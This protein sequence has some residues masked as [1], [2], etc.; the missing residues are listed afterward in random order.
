MGFRSGAYAKVWDVS[1]V[2]DAVTTLR[3]SIS[4]KDKK[5]GDYVDDFSG[6]IRVIG[7]AAAKNASLIKPGDRIRLGDVDVS[8]R[9]DRDKKVEYTTYKVFGFDNVSDNQ[10]NSNV[11][12]D[13]AGESILD[14]VDVDDQSLPF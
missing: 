4:R 10:S 6:F 12:G 11:A 5:T 9:Y 8:T 13:V 3:I 14:E 1:P 7:T 2:S